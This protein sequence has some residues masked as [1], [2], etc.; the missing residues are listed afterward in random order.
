VND[1]KCDIASLGIITAVFIL[2]V[3]ARTHLPVFSDSWYHLSVIRAF[4]ERGLT[5]NAWW[6]FAPFGRPHLYS[7]LLH[8]L[9]AGLMRMTGCSLLSLATFYEVVTFPVL[10]LAGWGTARILFGARAALVTLLLLLL[11][12]GLLFPVSLIIMPGTYAV[13]LWPYLA[14]LV[15]RKRWLA[16]AAV[17]TTMCYLHFGIASIAVVSLVLIDW[18][19]ALRV[20]GPAGLAFSPWLVHLYRHREYLHSGVANLPVFIPVFTMLAAIAG[21]VALMRKKD[22]G[23]WAV[24]AMILA[25][26]LF[27]F[28]LRERFWTYGGVLF[29]LLGGFGVVRLAEKQLRWIVPVLAVSC[30]TVTPFLKPPTMKLALP[31]PLQSSPFL[32]GTP[33]STLVSLRQ[34][35]PVPAELVTLADW[36]SHNVGPDEIIITDDRLLGESLFALTGRRTTSGLWREVMTPELAA[37]LAEYNQTG[38]GYIIS[39]DAEGHYRVSHR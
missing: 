12:I 33:V 22:K 9:G 15:L 32:M 19:F 13:M 20:V 39:R 8:V 35:D 7:P 14:I 3:G 1:R 11:N 29:A 23:A 37:Q 38:K 34:G 17:L 31:V 28:T 26:G 21:V 18:K 36:I 4:S 2:M 30:V 5:G 24:A 10:L 6:E 16:G 27:L 25:S